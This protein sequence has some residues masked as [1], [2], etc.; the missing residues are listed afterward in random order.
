M[1]L[2]AI[3][4]AI[5]LGAGGAQAADHAPNEL[6]DDTIPFTFTLTDSTLAGTSEFLAGFTVTME[7]P[8]GCCPGGLD[9]DLLLGA[10]REH[11]VRG[12]LTSSSGRA[13][14]IAYEVIRHRGEETIYMKTSQGYFPWENVAIAG[15]ELRMTVYWWYMP[16]A[17]P[18]DLLVV[19]RAR[20]LLAE[21]ERWQQADDRNCADDS[22]SGRWSLFCA[23]KQ[24]S[25]ATLG[26]YNHHSRVMQTARF[27]IDDLLPEHG[28]DHTLMDYNNSPTTTHAGVLHVLVRTH[29][30][31]AAAL[32][33]SREAGADSLAGAAP[34]PPR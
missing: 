11:G 21:P 1:R 14:P 34:A 30:R 22:T 32:T 12:A 16:P 31:L 6:P 23:L 20:E 19:E 27:V 5:A 29:E 13:S 8:R 15:D 17:S 3:L 10:V 2:P 9:F 33:A 24:A 4:S 26:E 7:L 25:L 28:F 18:A